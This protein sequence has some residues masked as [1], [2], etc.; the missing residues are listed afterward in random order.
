[1]YFK[2]AHLHSRKM[3]SKEVGWWQILPI[4]YFIFRY[5]LPAKL[6]CFQDSLLNSAL[7]HK[8]CHTQKIKLSALSP[9]NTISKIGDS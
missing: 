6:L 7:M 5:N 1:M 8:T 2:L 4:S 3:Q 9:K